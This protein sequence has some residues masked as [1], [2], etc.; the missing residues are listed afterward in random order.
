[1]RLSGNE[2]HY[3][4]QRLAIC[5]VTPSFMNEQSEHPPSEPQP[6]G[7]T[8]AYRMSFTGTAGEYFRIWIVNLLLTVV[9]LGIYLPWAIVRKRKY[10]YG[11]TWLAEDNFGFHANPVALLKGYMIVVTFAVIYGLGGYL[12]P[13]IPAI[14]V[15]LVLLLYPFIIWKVLRFRTRNS[16]YRNIRFDFSGTLPVAYKR[17]LIWAILIPFTLGLI[18]PYLAYLQKDY[19]FNNLSFGDQESKFKGRAGL[20]YLTYLS[21]AGWVFLISFVSLFLLGVTF[22][23]IENFFTIPFYTGYLALIPIYAL[24]LFALTLARVLIFVKIY[25]HVWKNTTLGRGISF[26]SVFE[27]WP[28]LKIQ[29]VNGLAI[30]FSLG[31]AIPWATVRK[32]KYLAECMFVS[33]DK[34]QLD[35]VVQTATASDTALGDAAVDYLDFDI[36]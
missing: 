17:F 36:G 34:D 21:A 26:R 23:L 7:G 1:M 33:A 28:Y 25:N 14:V 10:L 30:F 35:K 32:L 12:N 27:L 6:G 8:K 16:S 3:N 20:F 11:N 22:E 2:L 5:R 19:M 31:L 29:V 24:L 13:I 4:I 15:I 9:T 18:Y